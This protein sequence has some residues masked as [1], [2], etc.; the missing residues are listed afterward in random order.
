MM[1]DNLDSSDPLAVAGCGGRMVQAGG[2]RRQGGAQDASLWV[3]LLVVLL[4]VASDVARAARAT[5]KNNKSDLNLIGWQGESHKVTTSEEEAKAGVPTGVHHGEEIDLHESI[6]ARKF[7]MPDRRK[8]PKPSHHASTIVEVEGG[9]L[10]AA[11]FAGKFEGKDDVGIFLSRLEDYQSNWTEPVEL[12]KPTNGVPTWNPVLF[13]TKGNEVLLFYKTGRNP[14]TWKG[15]V[16]RS[17]DEGVTWSE[18][19]HLGAGIIGPAKNKPI[20]L[21]DGTIIAPSSREK[22]NRVWSCMMEES[23]DGGK[24]WKAWGPIEFNGRIIQ[25]SVW[26]DDSERVRMVARSRSTYMVSAKSDSTGREFGKPQLTTIPC[27]NSDLDA[28]KLKDGRVVLI[29]NHSFKK[30]GFAGRQIISLAVSQDDGDS[31]QEVT[32][33]ESSKRNV[34]FSYPSIIQSDDELVHVTYT[35]KR[36]NI[37]HLIIDPTKL[38]A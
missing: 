6:V 38:P 24:T 5:H 34:E 12:V 37:R 28:V 21:S 23:T 15:Y 11:W 20:Q 19:E 33:L 27:P 13:R 3:S 7:V 31:W 9:A 1:I 32:T 30:G 10:L 25:P 35:W 22:R 4:L 18:P 14:Q 16:K 36:H 26:I 29:Y 17:L 2:R 8:R